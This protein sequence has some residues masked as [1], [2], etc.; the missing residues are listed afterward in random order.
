MASIRSPPETSHLSA[1]GTCFGRRLLEVHKKGT[2]TQ[3]VADSIESATIPVAENGSK[4][5]L[6]SNRTGPELVPAMIEIDQ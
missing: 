4:I 3:L 2:R 1:A 6:G 5:Q